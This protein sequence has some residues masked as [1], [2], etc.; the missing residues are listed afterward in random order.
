M[1]QS[2]SVAASQAEDATLAETDF[3][4]GPE[5]FSKLGAEGGYVEDEVGGRFV[6]HLAVGCLEIVGGLDG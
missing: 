1:A 3:A 5:L 4:E 2:E 6:L